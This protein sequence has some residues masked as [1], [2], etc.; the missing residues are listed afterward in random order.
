MKN[1]EL[2]L[3][4]FSVA[5]ANKDEIKPTINPLGFTRQARQ[6][7]VAS[8]AYQP[9]GCLSARRLAELAPGSGWIADRAMGLKD[10]GYDIGRYAGEETRRCGSAKRS[11]SWN[12]NSTA[13]RAVRTRPSATPPVLASGS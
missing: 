10:G 9:D 4:S 5:A 6:V 2:P 7:S 3:L 11:G 1:L 8:W 13:R 12:A